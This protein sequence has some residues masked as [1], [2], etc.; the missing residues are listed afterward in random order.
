MYVPCM[1]LVCMDLYVEYMM[2]YYRCDMDR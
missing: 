2:R 1:L